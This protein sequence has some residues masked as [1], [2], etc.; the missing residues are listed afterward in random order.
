MPFR[1]K[2]TSAK[3]Q[4]ELGVIRA[5]VRWHFSFAY[6]DDIVFPKSNKSHIEP[7]RRV[8]LL[9]YRAGATLKMKKCKFIVRNIDYFGHVIRPCLTKLAKHNTESAVKLQHLTIHPGLRSFLDLRK[10]FE[11]VPSNFVGLAVPVNKKL[12]KTQPKIFAPLDEMDFRRRVGKIGA[13]KLTGA[14]STKK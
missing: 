12:R 7:V 11:E 8:L 10:C 3:L 14:D 5:S 1:L 9:P 2:S 13:H 6:S 4:E